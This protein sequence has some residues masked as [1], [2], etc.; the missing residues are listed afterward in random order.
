[1][2]T[3]SIRVVG[4][5]IRFLEMI[6]GW[7]HRCAS[8][9]FQIFSSPLDHHLLASVVLTGLLHRHCPRPTETNYPLHH[10]TRQ[11]SS[12]IYLNQILLFCPIL[13]SIRS[14]QAYPGS[15]KHL[16]LI[17]VVPL[18]RLLFLFLLFSHERFCRSTGYEPHELNSST[19]K[20]RSEGWLSLT[21]IVFR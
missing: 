21:I 6:K 18:S 12:L 1:M 19:E 7:F 5:K 16:Y 10:V 4:F 20:G 17:C 9:W 11:F 3:S 2:D 8:N 14:S 13:F 15:A